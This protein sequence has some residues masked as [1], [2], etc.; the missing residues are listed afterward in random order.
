VIYIETRRRMG[1]GKVVGA[2]PRGKE[3]K[4]KFL[5]KKRFSHSSTPLGWWA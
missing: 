5:A 4:K 1:R 2:N 3:T